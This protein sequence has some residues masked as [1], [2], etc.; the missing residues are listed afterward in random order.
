[1]VEE[2]LRQR[3]SALGIIIALRKN[4]DSM[5]GLI[6]DM[7]LGE[8][9]SALDTI[10]ATGINTELY[11]IPLSAVKPRQISFNSLSGTSKYSSE[12]YIEKPFFCTKMDGLIQL[13]KTEIIDVN[14]DAL[15]IIENILGRFHKVVR[16]LIIRHSARP[17]ITI[18]D[19]YDVQDLLHGLLRL[20]FDDIRTEEWTPKYAG[21]NNRMDFLLK[22]EQVAIEVKKTRANLKDKEVGEQLIIDIDRYKEH[23]NCK[24]LVCF[25]YDPDNLIANPTA[26]EKD[27]S[28]SA[29]MNVKV[30]I[31]PKV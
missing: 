31:F 2:K 9:Q 14:V 20:F 12:L 6:P 7:Y 27:L 13:L 22:D 19:E 17:T 21:G 4:L 29:K 11:R 1:M 28:K 10:S 24:T 15:S 16:Q 3:R 26:L 23:P 25:V 18:T 30:Y 8:Y 5:S